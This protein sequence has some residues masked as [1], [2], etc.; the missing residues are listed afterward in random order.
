MGRRGTMEINVVLVDDNSTT[1][2]HLADFIKPVSEVSIDDAIIACK[3]IP[4]P[5]VRSHPRQRGVDLDATFRAVREL[6]PGVAVIDL[7]LEGDAVD[8]YSG[9]DLALRV[10]EACRDCCIILVSHYFDEAPQLLDDIEI[11]RFRVDRTQASY[12]R[13][14]QKRFIEAVTQYAKAV[15]LRQL[16]KAPVY[17]VA[18]PFWQV[19]EASD[20]P[21]RDKGSFDVFLSHNSRDKPTVRQLAEVLQARG[22]K[23]WLDEQELVPGRRWAEALEEIIQTADTAAVLLGKDGMGPWENPEMRACLAEFVHRQLP[24]IPVL[25]PG[26]PEVAK[27][28]LFLRAFTLVD[29]RDGLTADGLN[30]L[31]WGITGK[32]PNR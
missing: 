20:R 4:L 27:L 13:K 28:P 10:K 2:R 9:A 25:L 11:F 18:S 3:L 8:D 24:V 5:P 12:G 29:L 32:K 14:L 26:A 7:K 23:V 17:G 6:N 22:L 30:R 21:R 31:E 19:S 1:L 15:A 16:L